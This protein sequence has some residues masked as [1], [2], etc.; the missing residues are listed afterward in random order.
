MSQ[1]QSTPKSQR[2]YALCR[3]RGMSPSRA[4][5]VARK[6]T[7]LSKFHGKPPEKYCWTCKKYDCHHVKP[8]TIEKYAMKDGPQ[9]LEAQE[10]ESLKAQILALNDSADPMGTI[11]LPHAGTV[12]VWKVDGD[13]VKVEHDMDFVEAGNGY[14]WP[15]I[16]KSEIWID[17]DLE[18]HDWCFNCLHECTEIDLMAQG[19]EYDPAHDRANK[20]EKAWRIERAMNALA[21]CVPCSQCGDYGCD[22][23]AESVGKYCVEKYAMRKRS[24][25]GHG[26]AHGAENM[27]KTKHW[28]TI[29]G[30]PGADGKHVGG[31]HVEVEGGTIVK[32]PE[33][34]IGNSPD[35][36]EGDNGTKPLLEE[37]HRHLDEAH[38]NRDIE[39]RNDQGQR[40]KRIEEI[41]RDL[42]HRGH[43]VKSLPTL[44][45][46]LESQ[47][48]QSELRRVAEQK[49]GTEYDP[50]TGEFS[51][52]TPE[53]VGEGR[54][55]LAP[56]AAPPTA[57]TPKEEPFTLAPTT[58]TKKDT[59]V[60]ADHG[61]E[62]QKTMLST[63]GA[64]GQQDLF[65]TEGSEPERGPAE[66][67][68]PQQPAVQ[69][70]AAVDPNAVSPE[71]AAAQQASLA[72]NGP[73]PP[74]LREA[75]IQSAK[76]YEETF[77]LGEKG[78]SSDTSQI[79]NDVAEFNKKLAA[80]AGTTNKRTA[81]KYL[82][83]HPEQASTGKVVQEDK[84]EVVTETSRQKG[85]K[86]AA[87]TRSQRNQ[88]RLEFAKARNQERD[89]YAAEEAD[90]LGVSVDDLRK[91]AEDLHKMLGANSEL[92]NTHET[93]IARFKEMTGKT[94]EDI[95]KFE[96]DGGDF[97]DEYGETARA[98]AAEFP[99]L[100]WGHVSGENE[101]LEST[102]F[103]DPLRDL[104]ASGPESS[105]WHD[106]VPMASEKIEEY[107]TRKA[108]EDKQKADR[109]A[110][111][112]YAMTHP[113]ELSLEDE[114]AG[115]A[116][117]RYPDEEG[118]TQ[119]PTP[120]SVLEDQAP[121]EEGV[122]KPKP[123]EAPDAAEKPAAAPRKTLSEDLAEKAKKAAAR[124]QTPEEAAKAAEAA[125]RQRG[126]KKE[127]K[128]AGSKPTMTV[129][130][131]EAAGLSAPGREKKKPAGETMSVEEAKAA[132]VLDENGIPVKPSKAPKPKR[133][134]KQMKEQQG[135]INKTIPAAV[136]AR[137]KKMMEDHRAKVEKS[138]P[139]LAKLLGQ[140][141]A[142]LADATSPMWD[143]RNVTA[144]LHRHG[145]RVKSSSP[146][147]KTA[148]HLPG[149]RLYGST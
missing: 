14:R 12:T 117:H 109:F 41:D 8:M 89:A 138:D 7:G 128:P 79:D 124:Q 143:P 137:T 59:W 110:E 107:N 146:T 100:G 81:A 40:R 45:Q 17:E 61:K 140:W 116:A 87:A 122:E 64:P 132:G 94:P 18:V 55:P 78:E 101:Q 26:S 29:G 31:V 73:N 63:G 20:R 144:A 37:R 114:A 86:K 82:T 62:T 149:G 85:A 111:M 30:H 38:K 120:R 126:G 148:T 10:V 39:S 84:P 80:N 105:S 57:E 103:A 106:F 56:P 121:A 53:A 47:S 69:P 67:A 43:D 102:N 32:G 96:D 22:H 129:E 66:A 125:K 46:H 19:M 127:K 9:G 58:D 15:F 72:K 135:E 76:D 27:D 134:L 123:Q 141:I 145:Q 115:L 71:R 36:P 35:D 112:E 97:T 74:S 13:A 49:R 119:E 147:R 104:L 52:P 99:D 93:A 44:D 2:V 70:P 131:A 42:A 75:R 25:A 139:E 98:I 142:S 4:A 88:T 108:W 33:K 95:D 92:S 113:G 54:H 136:K 65:N 51:A 24:I 28:I 68:A 16:P 23:V 60:P 3:K 11:T 77:Q 48:M 34:M 133:S 6:S 118:H 50:A 5:T 1:L 90:N 130:E 83:D 21:E 91:T